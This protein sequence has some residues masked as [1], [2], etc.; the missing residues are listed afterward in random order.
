[1]STAAD[2]SHADHGKFIAVWK[3]VDGEWKIVHD[4][5]NSSM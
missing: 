5:F 4:I 1:M 3:N 2:G